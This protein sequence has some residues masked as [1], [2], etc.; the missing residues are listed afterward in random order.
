MFEQ[1]MIGFMTIAEPTNF[2]AVLMGVVGGMI[3]GAMPGLTAPMGCALLIPFTYG[4]EPVAAITMLVSLYCGATYGGSIAAILVHAPG[5]PA[6]A[7]AN[8]AAVEMFTVPAPSPP[9]PQVSTLRSGSVTGTSTAR[10]R[11]A[12]AAAATSTPVSPF[13]RSATRTAATCGPSARPSMT[14]PTNRSTSEPSRS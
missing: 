4:M 9:V 11:M 6:A 1:L 8:A 3:L 7:A 12:R 10:C 2:L 14:S 13:I 5:T